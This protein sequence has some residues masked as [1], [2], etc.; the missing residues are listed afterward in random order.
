VQDAF[1]FLNTVMV[2]DLTGAQIRSVLEQGF[3][4]ERGMVQVS[5]LVAR[6]DSSRPE[7]QRLLEL[8]IGGSPVE[9]ERSYR[10]ATNSFVA[11][12]GDLYSMFLDGRVVEEVD[13]DI[14]LVV[15]DYLQ[16]Q[17]GPV[18]APEMGRLVPVNEK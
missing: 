18:P 11:E 8:S 1:P 14:A 9:D 3:T 17:S 5:G 10:V 16:K 13:K 4:L 12:G 2:V 15:V 7:G 6:Y